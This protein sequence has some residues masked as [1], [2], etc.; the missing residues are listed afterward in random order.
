MGNFR[1]PRILSWALAR[2]AEP[3][4]PNAVHQPEGYASPSYTSLT[5]LNRR[6]DGPLVW[7]ILHDLFYMAAQI[8]LVLVDDWELRS[9]GTGDPKQLQFGPLR[10]LTR[11]LEDHSFRGP[12]TWK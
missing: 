12:L 5:I 10:E 2:R 3:E 9:D 11:L 4:H 6:Y 7:E 8:Y 1:W